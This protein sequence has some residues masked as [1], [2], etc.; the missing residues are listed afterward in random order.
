MA[1]L[2]VIRRRIHSVQNTQKITRAMKMVSAAKLRR[3]QEAATSFRGYADLTASIL[4]EVA[5]DSEDAAHP[6]LESREAER[7]LIVV[8]SSDRGLCG[9][10]NGNLCRAVEARLREADVKPALAIIGRKAADFFSHRDV[11]I[12]TRYR[13]VYD[14]PGYETAGRIAAALSALFTAGEVDRIELA[15]N[16][17]ESVMRQA[18]TV[19]PLLPIALDRAAETHSAEAAG[20]VGYTFEP[21]REHLLSLLLPKYVEVQMYR[22]LLES[23]A[24]EHAARMTAMDAATNN[25]GEMIDHFTLQYNR[26]RQ[27]AITKELM[28]IVGGAEALGE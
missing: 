11:E 7:A 15:F 20:P 5:R 10:F 14:S 18:P 25:A 8:I 2:K 12:K 24:A 19:K 27:D 9:A 3:A 28:D 16:E 4:N 17:F 23:I 22:A 26:A 1:N 6:L 21:D 13:E